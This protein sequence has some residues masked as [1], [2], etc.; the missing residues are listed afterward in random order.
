M[1][2]QDHN[3][4]MASPKVM[5]TNT[6]VDKFSNSLKE[7]GHFF[8]K[9][10][11]QPFDEALVGFSPTCKLLQLLH[12]YSC[13]IQTGLVR[14]QHLHVVVQIVNSM[15]QAK[16]SEIADIEP[17]GICRPVEIIMPVTVVV[18]GSYAKILESTPSGHSA[19]SFVMSARSTSKAK[20]IKLISRDNPAAD[21]KVTFVITEC[22]VEI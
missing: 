2:T 6:A 19:E 9:T 17:G 7:R 16:A 1:T 15:L 22:T 3:A 10:A 11:R 13:L 12:F 8:A 21:S 20:V 18:L 14:S 5:H 4:L